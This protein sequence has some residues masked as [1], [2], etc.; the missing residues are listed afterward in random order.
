MHA[1]VSNVGGPKESEGLPSLHEIWVVLIH[2]HGMVR[3]SIAPNL[4][5][6]QYSD[7][8]KGG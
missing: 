3:K 5:V 6:C 4:G 1:Y 2:K 8:Q 7:M